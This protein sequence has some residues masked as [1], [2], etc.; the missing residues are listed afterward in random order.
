[1]CFVEF[2][3]LRIL[4]DTSDT[5]KGGAVKNKIKLQRPK[6]ESS[7]PTYNMKLDYIDKELSNKKEF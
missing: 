4:E 1:M 5:S 7:H 2:K 6:V 3:N